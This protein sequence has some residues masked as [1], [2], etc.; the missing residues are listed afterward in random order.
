RGVDLAA[1]RA[2]G[3]TI[4]ERDVARH[5]AEHGAAGQMPDDPRLVLVGPATARRLRVARDLRA[6]AHASVFTTLAYRLALRG[7]ERA[8]AAELAAGRAASL[9]VLL[10]AA[11][12]RT[13]P[14]FPDLVSV[15]AQGTIYRHRDI[16]VAFAARSPAGELH[17]PV[18]RRVD[19]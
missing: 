17:A 5:L 10:L 1:V 15:L 12:G 13:L 18:V 16:D 6:A 7:P 2:V 4:Q 8:I 19:R 9:L 11:L 14:Q 3:A